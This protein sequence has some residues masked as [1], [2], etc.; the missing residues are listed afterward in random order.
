M[1]MASVAL[2]GPP[3]TTLAAEIQ[4]RK[5]GD[6]KLQSQV[7]ALTV[8]VSKLEQA[9]VPVPSPTPTPVI[10]PVPGQVIK[11]LPTGA[12]QSTFMSLFTDNAV[13]V[14]ECAG[15]YQDYRVTDA[16]S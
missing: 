8:R 10:E 1:A 7:D 4:A 2:G 9:A 11:Q 6:A 12:P 13:D 16:R 5:D 3:M 14:I 15:K